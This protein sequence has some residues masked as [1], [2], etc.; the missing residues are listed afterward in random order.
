MTDT[1]STPLANA[2][3]AL[4]AAQFA[5]GFLDFY[6][7]SNVLLASCK[8]PI[9]P[10][11]APSGGV[12]SMAGQWFGTVTASGSHTVS[13]G[14]FRNADSSVWRDVSVGGSGSGKQV[15][16]STTT[17]AFG[18]VVEVTAFSYIVPLTG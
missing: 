14:R 9:A 4:F 16:V 13:R 2:L 12:S 3:A 11:T 5:D 18:D 1:V 6:D 7:A 8:L 15:I 10:F 17:F